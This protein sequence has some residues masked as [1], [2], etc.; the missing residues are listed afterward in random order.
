MFSSGTDTSKSYAPSRSGRTNRSACMASSSAACAAVG[1]HS[2][3]RYSR[4]RAAAHRQ[5][6]RSLPRVEAITIA[7]KEAHDRLVP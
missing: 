4:V 2:E 5:R 7:V 6:S 3:L 1:A